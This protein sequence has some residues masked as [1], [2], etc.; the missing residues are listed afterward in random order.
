[1]QIDLEGAA[2]NAGGRDLLRA[3]RGV[4]ED[5]SID[6]RPIMPVGGDKDDW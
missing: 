4:I 3:P 2:F 5:D 6:D 1:V